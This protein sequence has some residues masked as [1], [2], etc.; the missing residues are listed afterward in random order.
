[1]LFSSSLLFFE[2]GIKQVDTTFSHDSRIKTK[3]YEKDG[4]TTRGKYYDTHLQIE[5]KQTKNRVAKY[6]ERGIMR[7]KI[8][9]CYLNIFFHTTTT[10]NLLKISKFMKASVLIN[11]PM[12]VKT[13]KNKL[14]FS[15]MERLFTL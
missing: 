10:S 3:A 5:K 12:F 13:V 2:K 1:M 8:H 14:I 9:E 15:E 7:R 6:E 4:T 11:F